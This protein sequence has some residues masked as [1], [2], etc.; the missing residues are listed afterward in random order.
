VSAAALTAPAPA[1][2]RQPA[3]TYVVRLR[4][5]S[6]AW[7]SPGMPQDEA[8]T[9]ATNM[10]R[11][12]ADIGGAYGFVTFEGRDGK[13]Y[14]LRAREIVAVELSPEGH[15]DRRSHRPRPT[16]T[17]GKVGDL[18][19]QVH[20][21]LPDGGIPASGTDWLRGQTARAERDHS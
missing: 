4:L 12:L 19:I 10:T 15:D 17:G 8:T 20:G 21:Q 3:P 16:A 13:T 1:P 11:Q 14:Q 7:S 5:E 18:S 2:A 9:L 6:H